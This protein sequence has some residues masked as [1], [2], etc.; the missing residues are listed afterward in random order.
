M[1][2]LPGDT[3]LVYTSLQ[4]ILYNS[5]LLSKDK[6]PKTYAHPNL[7]KLFVAFMASPE[8]Q[9]VVEKYEQRS[10]HLVAGT[11]MA[12]YVKQNRLKLQSASELIASYHEGKGLE[13]RAELTNMLKQ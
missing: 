1:E 2:I 11:R 6:A 5:K 7:A 4:G 13:F 8:A 10:S 12:N 3:V 9:R